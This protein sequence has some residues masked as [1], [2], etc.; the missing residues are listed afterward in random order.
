[1]CLFCYCL[2][3]SVFWMGTLWLFVDLLSLLSTKQG[4]VK[5][6]EKEKAK[7]I[8]PILNVSTW[9]FLKQSQPS[10]HPPICDI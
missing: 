4:Q 8:D 10:N 6:R 9:S 2:S 3:H 5:L 1:M 7:F